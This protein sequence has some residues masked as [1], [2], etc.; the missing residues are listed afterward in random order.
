MVQSHVLFQSGI[1]WGAMS[2]AGIGPLYFLRYKVKAA[3]YQKVL[4]HIIQTNL[5]EVQISFSNRAWHLYTLLTLPVPGLRTI[6]SPFLISQK[7]ILTL[8]QLKIY[9][10]CEEMM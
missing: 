2:S 10:Y 5:I 1:V 6:V 4:E 3:V 8:T 9:A 7:T